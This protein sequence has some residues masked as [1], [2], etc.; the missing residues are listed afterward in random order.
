MV[1][2][3]LYHGGVERAGGGFLGV[4][5]FFVLSGYLITSLLLAEGGATGRI[6][7]RAF[8]IRRAR[9]LL[10]AL[11][12]VLAAVAVYAA[13][14]AAGDE[15]ARIRRDGLATL[16]YVANWRMVIGGDSYF[17]TLAVP[18]PLR[19]AWSLA[20]EEQWYVVWP[21]VVGLV[22]RR[23]R[24]LLAVTLVGAAASAVVMAA[25]SSDPSRA[26]YGT[27]ARAQALLLGGALALVPAWRGARH[28]GVLGL[29]V[30]TAMVVLVD[31]ATTWLYRGGFTLVA[32]ASAAVV[33]AAVAPDGPVRALLSTR[34]LRAVGRTSYGLYLWHWPLFVLLTPDRA[35]VDGGAL[36][37]VRLAV[38]GAV[39]YL[40]YSLV[41]RPIREGRLRLPRPRVAAPALGA[42]VAVALVLTT[43]PA[44][45]P[46][47][48]AAA[49]AVAGA[50]RVLVVGDSVA[51]TLAADA[52]AHVGGK[53]E[54][55]S[56]AILGCG[57]VRVVRYAGPRA[58]EPADDCRRWPQRWRRVLD[59]FRPDVAVLLIG[60][61]EVFD[62]QLDGEREPFGTAAHERLVRREVAA[63]LDVLG[64]GAPEVVA[65]TTP[66]FDHRDDDLFRDGSERND[67]ARVAWVNGIVRQ[68]AAARAGVRVV[69]LHAMVCPGGRYVTELDGVRIRAGDGV[70]FDREGTPLLW[71]R[72]LPALTG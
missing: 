15:V 20:I 2:V 43:I 52:T 33:A 50:P 27:D 42:A 70:H 39:A 12:L 28:A 67:P 48:V 21:L 46:P 9:R 6:D 55:T 30:V 18:S 51:M 35:G 40:S 14:A 66:C 64:R 68:E 49:P 65:L 22:W 62:V 23:P 13:V 11:A 31:D 71:R 36:L 4:D 59:R 56:A 44:A 5:V 53:A 10:P 61:W 24:R 34:A 1:A 54:V 41:E 37:A 3:L 72:L 19:H 69:D 17:E 16:L 38:T 32:V 45:R 26:Y 47:V 7:L 63:A 58:H 57:V 60:A 29:A 25:V 8:W